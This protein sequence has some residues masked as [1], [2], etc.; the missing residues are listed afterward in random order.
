MTIEKLNTYKAFKPYNIR[1]RYLLINK[2]RIAVK[3]SR[4]PDL[5]ITE[6]HFQYDGNWYKYLKIGFSGVT[7]NSDYR[8]YSYFVTDENGKTISIKRSYIVYF[9]SRDTDEIILDGYE[10]DHINRN[11][12]DDSLENLRY[13]TKLENMQNRD[14]S[15]IKEKRRSTTKFSYEVPTHPMTLMS[16][17]CWCKRRDFDINDFERV[18]SP[19]EFWLKSKRDKY[20]KKYYWTSKEGVTTS[21]DECNGGDIPLM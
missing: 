6:N 7:K 15:E 10:I 1:D 13:V 8:A 17:K 18:E 11:P 12:M 5:S 9:C 14:T 2:E 19:S 16:F 4:R 21:H 20:V 3:L